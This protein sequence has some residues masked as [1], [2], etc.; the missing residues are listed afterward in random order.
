MAYATIAELKASINITSTDATRDTVLTR[1][2]S[3]A[4]DAIDKYCNRPDGFVAQTLPTVRYYTGSGK[5]YQWIDE[6]TSVTGVAVKEDPDDT[7]YT[8]WALTDFVP[9]SGDPKSPDFNSTPYC[10]I[11]C[12]LNGDYSYFLSGRYSGRGI[13]TVQVTAK[14]GY[15]T[16]VPDQVKE[17]AIVQAA[18]WYKRGESAWADTI[19]NNELGTL[20][21]RKSI[22]PD[23]EMMLY[24]L[25]KPAIG[26]R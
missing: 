7:T 18:R 24:R 8:A 17:A 3:A 6:T 1:L 11:M 4:D 22:D 14:F 9:F 5:A 10:A 23:L 20:S 25:R 12:T 13:M 2:L 16:V 15:A 26:R 21:F 19:A